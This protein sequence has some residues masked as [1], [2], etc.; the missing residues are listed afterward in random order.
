MPTARLGAPPVRE[1]SDRLA[2][3]LRERVHARAGSSV[4]PQLRDRLGR[5]RRRRADRAGR[6]VDREVDAR[7]ERAG[8][9]QRHHGDERLHEHRA[10]ADHARVGLRAASSFGV[11]PD[12]MSAWNPEI[13]PHAIVMN[14][15]GK[16]LPAN[17]GPVPSMNCVSA[18]IWSGGSATRM[19]TAEREHDADLHE[20][21]RDS[22]AARAAATPAAPTRRSR[23]P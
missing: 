18:G 2:D 1:S 14:A 19:P 9:D 12:A 22:R 6:R 3:L 10:V 17:T 21:R 11:V 16:T 15:N 13:A 4:K 20:R 5:A 23:R 8:R 7:G